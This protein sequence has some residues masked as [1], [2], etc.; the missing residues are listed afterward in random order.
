MKNLIFYIIFNI[1]LTCL[2][3]KLKYVRSMDKDEQGEK[4]SLYLKQNRNHCIKQYVD[5]FHTLTYA[6]YASV[7]M[8]IRTHTGQLNFIPLLITQI[9]LWTSHWPTVFP[10]FFTYLSWIKTEQC[11]VSGRTHLH[12][13]RLS[14]SLLL[15][16]LFGYFTAKKSNA[17]PLRHPSW[18]EGPCWS[19]QGQRD[20]SLTLFWHCAL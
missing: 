12:H 1:L 6:T 11:T 7:P 10:L 19:P 16:T 5:H 13:L 3:S 18:E 20:T 14:L 15:T 17:Q 8:T 2:C 9:M 4:G